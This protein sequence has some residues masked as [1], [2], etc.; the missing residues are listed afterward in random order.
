MKNLK[1]FLLICAFIGPVMFALNDWLYYDLP[2]NP[3]Y[4]PFLEHIIIGWLIIITNALTLTLLY[5][6]TK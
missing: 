3:N 1:Y 5:K 2:M 4:K 6:E